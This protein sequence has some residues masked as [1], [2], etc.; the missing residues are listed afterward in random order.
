MPRNLKIATGI[1]VAA[2]LIGLISLRGL[3]RRMTG[4]AESQSSDEAARREVLAPEISTSS[5][6]KVE[7]KIYWAAG[8]DRVA[9]TNVALALSAE[10]ALRGK[11]VLQALIANPTT[12]EQRTIPGDTALL[13]F[14]ILP[15]GTA[16]ADFST[17]LSAETPSG[18]E[19]EQVVVDSISRTL[20]SNV[21]T[22]RRL[23][24]LINGQEVDTLAG[25]LDLTGFFD[26]NS[27]G[28]P[29]TAVTPNTQAAPPA[30]PADSKAPNSTSTFAPAATAPKSPH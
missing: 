5:D 11:Q 19:S 9:P 22:A 3:Q 23:K 7:T 17:P 16:I 1:L 4:L 13:G 20:E 29:S 28:S 6:V 21:P 27:P 24:I 2:V 18:I 15:D 12:A 14:Y 30:A 10:P 26:L 8:E 25:H